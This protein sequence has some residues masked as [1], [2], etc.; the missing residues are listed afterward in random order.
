M[1]AVMEKNAFALRDQIA[2]DDTIELVV[3]LEIG[4]GRLITEILSECFGIGLVAQQLLLLIVNEVQI[5]D[6]RHVFTAAT[7]ARGREIIV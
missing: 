7:G 4:S 2:T 3:V 6:V 5:F 1:Q